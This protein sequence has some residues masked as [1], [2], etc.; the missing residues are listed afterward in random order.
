MIR[1]PLFSQEITSTNAWMNERLGTP[2][3]SN[4]VRDVSRTEWSRTMSPRKWRT[5]H[6]ARGVQSPSVLYRREL[7]V[8][9]A[10]T[11]ENTWL[12]KY[13]IPDDAI[14]AVPTADNY[15]LEA[16]VMRK[17]GMYNYRILYALEVA[18][19]SSIRDLFGYTQKK[20]WV[21]KSKPSIESRPGQ[22]NLILTPKNLILAVQYW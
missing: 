21:L 12:G 18:S 13:F 3:R 5:V 14:P 6:H 10:G 11:V 9:P 17:A 2:D 15:V 20:R 7:Y 16:D 1:R 8:P 22:M 4:P 19:G